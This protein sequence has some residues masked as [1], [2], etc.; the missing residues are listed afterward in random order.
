MKTNSSRASKR[1][2]VSIDQDE[3]KFNFRKCELTRTISG[4]KIITTYLYRSACP[5][6]LSVEQF[7]RTIQD[8]RIRTIIDL[9]NPKERLNSKNYFKSLENVDVLNIQFLK[10]IKA[11]WQDPK[12]KDSKSTANRYFEMLEENHDSMFRIFELISQLSNA[13]FLVHCAAGRDRTGIACAMILRAI[14]AQID[15][16]AEDYSKSHEVVQDGY[17]AERETIFEL[18][19]LIDSKYNN[20]LNFL[21]MCNI[22]TQM[23]DLIKRKC[24]EYS[25]NI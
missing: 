13:P 7:A 8:N 2:Y 5:E 22:D 10:S 12:T 18:F 1:F 17:G 21:K 25:S 16:I 20:F 24:V 6:K 19:Q 23:I 3:A 11:E 14:G 4:L 15:E 9:R